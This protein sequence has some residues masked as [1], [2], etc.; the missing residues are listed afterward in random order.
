MDPAVSYAVLPS[1][2]DVVIFGS[3]TLTVLGTNMHGSFGECARKRKLSAQDVKSLNFKEYRRVSIAVEALLQHDPG[4]SE[5]A[6]EAV[7]RLVSR[8]SDINT[9]Q[10][11]RS[12]SAPSPESRQWRLRRQ[13]VCRPGVRRGCARSWI[14]PGTFF[15]RGLRDSPA[16]VEPLTVAFEP[17]A[18]VAKVRGRVYR[19]RMAGNMYGTLVVLGLVFRNPQA[20]WASAAIAA[21]KKG[22]FRLMSDYRAVN[23][24]IEKVRGVMPNQEAEMVDLRGRH[25]LGRLICCKII[26]RCR[27]RPKPRK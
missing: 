20:V 16:R 21:P 19:D 7:K 23:K 9:E 5:P 10:S 8:G 3:P 1:K 12:A 25:V 26:S 13:M 11:K 4:A 24:Q 17:E 22:G 6:D 14:G 18:K 15:R 27:W 2:E